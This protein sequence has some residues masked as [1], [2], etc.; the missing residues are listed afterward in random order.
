MY[1]LTREHVNFVGLSYPRP[2]AGFAKAL[3]KKIFDF[4]KYKYDTVQNMNVAT[5]VNGTGT[6]IGSYK[7]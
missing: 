1:K 5:S 2:G 4:L 3:H 6:K 7:I